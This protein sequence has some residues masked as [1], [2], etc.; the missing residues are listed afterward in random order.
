MSKPPVRELLVLD[1]PAGALEAVLEIPAE[2][3][4]IGAA[5]VCHPHPQHGGTLQNKV[6]HTL[7]RVGNELGYASLR[8]N[9]RGVGASEGSYDEGIGEQDDARAAIEYARQRFSGELLL[10]GF[11]FGSIVA[12]EVA[13]EA[14]PTQL[15]S[16][17]PPVSRVLLTDDWSQPQCPWLIVQGDQD[18]LV[19]ADEVVTWVDSLEPG[20]RLIVMNNVDHFFH[21]QLVNLRKLLVNE[22][23]GADQNA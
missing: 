2:G 8:F 5:V 6:A 16:I 10:A 3:E 18:E 21:G 23:G 15:V 1:G 11:S 14:H 17:A 7:A 22:L 12:L 20:P 13:R 19:D 9:F 4:V